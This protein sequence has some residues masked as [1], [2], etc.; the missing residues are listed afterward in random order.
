MPRF[1]T[2]FSQDELA[3]LLSSDGVASVTRAKAMM[4]W[5]YHRTSPLPKVLPLR[6]PGVSTKLLARV[7][8]QV[9]LPD[10]QVQREQHAADGTVKLGLESAGAPLETVMIPIKQRTTVCVSSQSGCAR[11]CSF[12]ATAQMGLGRNLSAGEIVAQVVLAASF[13]P[14]ERRVRNVVFMGMGE[15]MDNLEAVL[16]AVKILGEPSGFGLSP[17]RITVSSVGVLPK[18][19]RFARE[20]PASLALSLNATSDALRQQ[21]IPLN[22]RWPLADIVAFIKKWGSADRP[23]FV[24]YILIDGVNNLKQD[25]DRLISMLAGLWVRLNLIP[26]NPTPG[27][28]FRAPSP[29]AVRLFHR[30][31]I[32]AGLPAFVRT[33]RGAS[34]QAACGQLQTGLKPC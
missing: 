26:V 24:E 34:I 25:A 3:Q 15:P 9:L 14:A 32:D 22:R 19:E 18:L 28:A 23:I 1:L 13:S 4:R 30:A 29:D 2:G 21:L 17:R 27:S 7:R 6:I 10:L 5:L 16:Q 31:L 11:G 12:C 33:T 8:D 20:S